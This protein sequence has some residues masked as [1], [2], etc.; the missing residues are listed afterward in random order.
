MN[1]NCVAQCLAVVENLTNAVILTNKSTIFYFC[2]SQRSLQPERGYNH[3][4][5]LRLSS[6]QAMGQTVKQSA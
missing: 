4:P 5:C 2:Y 1:V 6:L 3:L